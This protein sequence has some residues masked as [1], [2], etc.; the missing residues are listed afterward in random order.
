[1]TGVTYNRS[2]DEML[3]RLN[4]LLKPQLYL[5]F[6]DACRLTMDRSNVVDIVDRLRN[7]QLRNQVRFQGEARNYSSL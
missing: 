5:H 7:R 6:D 3:C 4:Y 2:L 1:M